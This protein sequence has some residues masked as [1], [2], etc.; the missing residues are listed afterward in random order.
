MRFMLMMNTPRGGYDEYMR[1]P[2][3]L[4][5]ANIAFM[6]QFSAKLQASGELVST[7][8]LAAPTQA[9]L[10]RAG[11]DGQPITDG[12]FPESK[13][14]LAGYWIV[15][16]DN[17]QRA[18]EIAA[19]A[20]TAPGQAVTGKPMLEIEVREVMSHRPDELG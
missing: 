2:K 13:E 16:V 20:S 14:Y 5:E 8:G 11:Q 19:E 15:D 12:V 4:L 1:W 7:E 6:I 17:A 10:V 3:A 9:K 18:F